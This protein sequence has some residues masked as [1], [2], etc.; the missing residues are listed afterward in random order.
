MSAQKGNILLPLVSTITVIAVIAVGYFFYTSINNP[1]NKLTQ[2]TPNTLTATPTL[3]ATLSPTSTP[4]PTTQANPNVK[5]YTSSA[6]GISFNYAAKTDDS[7]N[8]PIEVKE[9]GKKIYVYMKTNYSDYTA[10]Q[11]V[12]VFTKN[13]SDSLDEALNKTILNGYDPNKCILSPYGNKDDSIAVRQ[14]RVPSS[15]DDDLETITEKA[16]SC[17]SPYTATNGIV[18]FLMNNN[19]PDKFIFLSIGQYSI[20]SGGN[21]NWQDTIKFL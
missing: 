3:T 1:T 9:I 8:Y 10:G 17:P 7:N 4:S 21:L 11:Y 14:I 2:Q 20:S 13:K 12:E 15:A 19:H 16:K 18:Y 6:L 5:T